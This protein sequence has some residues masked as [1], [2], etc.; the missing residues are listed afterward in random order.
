ML[1]LL[2]KLKQTV[3]DFAAREEKL[4]SEYHARSGAAKSQYETRNEKLEADWEASHAAAEADL[5]A[6]KAQA[7]AQ[8]DN[9]KNWIDRAYKKVRGRAATN[10]ESQDANWRG[11]VQSGMV[12][13]EQQR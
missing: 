6:R 11:Q 2:E 9:R 7:R 8:T 5:Q 13:A 12:E 4:E 1:A 3:R 10:I